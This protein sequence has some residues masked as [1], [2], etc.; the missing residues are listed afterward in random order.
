MN[1]RGR[2]SASAMG[3]WRGLALCMVI[4][5]LPWA[6]YVNL[7][8]HSESRIESD[9][10]STKAAVAAGAGASAGSSV[11]SQ[12]LVHEETKNT[13]AP[14][15]SKPKP[16]PKPATAAAAVPPA[17]PAPKAPP[18][19]RSAPAASAASDAAVM[20]FPDLP[21]QGPVPTEGAKPLFGAKHKGTDAIMALACKYPTIYY[22]RFVGSLRKAG[23][24]EDIVLAVS[25]VPKMKPGVEQYL[26]DTNVVAYGF[27]VDCK[28]P[29][30]CR[31]QDEFLGY[32]DPRPH[33]TF[34]NI[35]YALYEYWLRQYSDRS[36]ILILD[37]RDTFFQANPFQAAGAFAQRTPKFDLQMFGEN[38]QVATAAAIVE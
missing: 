25:P 5:I 4:V 2:N 24:A 23:Y 32:P 11:M 26:R 3:S 17:P 27:D 6:L 13:N 29:D 20:R 14:Q 1:S 31:L 18:A 22:K 34:A 15:K 28:G 8:T 33:R 21:V 37:F 9:I 30:N 12:L 19:P 7:H 10:T 16:K 36:Y 38:H 35:R